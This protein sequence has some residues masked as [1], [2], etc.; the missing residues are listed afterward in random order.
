MFLYNFVVG[1]WFIVL[2]YLLLSLRPVVRAHRR[3]IE[4]ASHPDH[5]FYKLLFILMFVCVPVWELWI[6][7]RRALLFWANRPTKSERQEQQR[8]GLFRADQDRKELELARENKVRA[9]KRREWLAANET[10]LYFNTVIGI[11]AVLPLDDFELNKKQTECARLN[12]TWTSEVLMP[13]PGIRVFVSKPGEEAIRKASRCTNILGSYGE[14][15]QRCREANCKLIKDESI[16]VP[17]VNESLL[18]FTEQ[19]GY[20]FDYRGSNWFFDMVE[21]QTPKDLQPIK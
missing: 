4:G 7:L 2:L 20:I 13:H 5:W 15:V 10:H 6:R 3:A 8:Q 19:D 16:F 11:T 14:L 1:Q 9:D 21:R 17:F 12:E 18:T